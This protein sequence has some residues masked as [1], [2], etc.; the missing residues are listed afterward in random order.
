MI[1]TL[2]L[3]LREGF[4]LV[5]ASLI[6]LFATAA[7]AALLVGLLGGSLGI[8]DAALGQLVRA[9]AVILALA[10]VIEAVTQNCVEFAARSWAGIGAQDRGR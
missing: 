1:E 6:P 3:A 2:G 9:L 7:L 4:G 8:R 5:I 10:L